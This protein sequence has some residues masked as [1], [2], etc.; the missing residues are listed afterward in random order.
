MKRKII[1]WAVL[2]G[3]FSCE[4]KENLERISSKEKDDSLK[5]IESP[6]LEEKLKKDVINIV[7]VGDIMIGSAYPSKKYLPKD[8]ATGSFSEVKNHLKGDIVFGNLEGVFLDE[9]ESQKCEDKEPQSCYVFRMPERYGKIIKE[10]GFNLMSTANN[11][12]GDFGLLGRKTTAK[13]LDDAGIYHAGTKEYP[14]V[15]FEK[16]NIKYGFCAFAPNKNMLSLLDVKKAKEIVR[17]LKSQTDITIV[18]FHGGAEG[19]EHVRVPKKAEIFYG[20]NRGDVH[21]FA[22]AVVDAGADIVLGHGPHVTRAVEVYKNKFIAYSLGNFNTYGRFS[23]TGDKGIAPLLDIKL[24]SN[25]DFLSAKVVSVKQTKEKGLELDAEN[26]AF[27][28]IKQL[29]KLDF[30]EQNL[31]FEENTIKL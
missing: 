5:K 20:E 25:G 26:R 23:L 21:H 7:A 14:V 19:T 17:E 29:T 2:L 10:A 8:D 4:K 3:L 30:P 31:K 18:S 1:F 11:H 13:V 22:R 12:A 28:R 24:K 6:Q 9:G 15:I 27:Q 16:D